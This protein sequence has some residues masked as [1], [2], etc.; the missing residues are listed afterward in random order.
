MPKSHHQKPHS[1]AVDSSW[2]NLI[3]NSADFTII[4]TDK[5]GII[6]SANHGALERL[7]YDPLELIGI[8]TPAILH[9]ATEVVLRAKEL[10]DELEEVIEPGF[11][12]FVAKARHGIVDENEWSYIRKDGSRFTVFLSVTALMD[13]EGHIEGYLGIGRDISIQKSMENKIEVQKEALEQTNRELTEANKLL[14]EMIQTDPL[15]HL[16]NRRGLHNCFEHEIERI[17]RTPAPLSMLLMD[18]DHF[19]QYNDEFGHLGGD[20]LLEKLSIMLKEHLRTN[21]CVARFGGEE[22]LF[23]LPQTDELTSV[24]IA[25]R[26]RVLIKNMDSLNRP[27]TASFGVSTLLTVDKAESIIIQFDRMM[28]QADKAMYASKSDG[29]NRVKHFSDINK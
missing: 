9:D 17:K 22:F 12:V 4:S 24:K 6:R 19:K 5:S 11:D 3:L 1:V 16:L 2:L 8:Y 27:V 14:H 10:S 18:L 15:T 23:L 26:Y 29:R 13:D 21:D 20:Q 28:E 7:G 25:E